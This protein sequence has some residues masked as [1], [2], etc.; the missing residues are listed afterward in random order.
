MLSSLTSVK[1]TVAAALSGLVLTGGVG[2][3]AAAGSLPGAAQDTASE[4]LGKVGVTVPGADGHSAGHADE[5]GSSADASDDTA[6]ETGEARSQGKGEAVSG[7]ATSDDL[8]G[9]EKGATVSEY[10][11]NT[12]SRAGDEHGAQSSKADEAKAKAD[13]K[14][15]DGDEATAKAPV[16]TPN[17]GGTDT[18]DDATTEKDGGASTSG[19]EKA[20]ET[21]E[22]HSTVGSENR[23]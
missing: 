19:T 1:V 15:T 5:R 16:E 11:S 3:A 7:M 23:P 4:L 22:G 21:S 20:D 10:A 12:K 14:A 13:A 2:A 6:E 18:A 17:T 8:E 9:K